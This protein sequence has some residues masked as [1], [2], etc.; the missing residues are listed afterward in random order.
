M[1]TCCIV[2]ITQKKKMF[3][4]PEIFHWIVQGPQRQVLKGVQ[5]TTPRHTHTDFAWT[6]GASWRPHPHHS[7]LS[8]CQSYCAELESPLVPHLEIIFPIPALP[9][10]LLKPKKSTK[11]LQGGSSAPINFHRCI[12]SIC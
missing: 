7:H 11:D 6:V 2:S 4:N 9:L 8:G 12:N 1:C 5:S 10:A 3:R